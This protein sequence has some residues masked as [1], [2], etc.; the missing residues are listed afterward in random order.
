MC[1]GLA[2]WY[3]LFHEVP[4]NNTALCEHPPFSMY[5]PHRCRSSQQIK[6]VYTCTAPKYRG[7]LPVQL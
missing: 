5:N 4:Q 2:P 7:L 3:V 6:A 1:Q